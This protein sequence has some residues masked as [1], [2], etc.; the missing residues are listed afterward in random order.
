VNSKQ[1]ILTTILIII[2]ALIPASLMAGVDQVSIYIPSFDGPRELGRN[3]ATVL[4]LQI[5]QT[6]R[7]APWPENPDNLHFGYG[8]IYWDN[9]TLG[10]QSH[11]EAER[12][13]KDLSMLAQMAFWGKAY[14]YGGGVVVQSNLSIPTYNDFREDKLEIW[15]TK[16]NGKTIGLDIPRRRIEMSSIVLEPSII[17]KYSLPSALKM[18]KNQVGDEEVGEVGDSYVAIKFV[19]GFAYVKSKG[20]KGWVRLPELSKRPTEVVDFVAGVIRIFRG[21]WR[22]A[23]TKMQDVIN[24]T[25]TKKPLKI[26]AYLYRGMAL[27][28]LGEPGRK[29]FEHAYKLNPY[30]ETTIQYLIM[31]DLSALNRLTGVNKTKERNTINERIRNTISEH[32]YLFKD[33]NPWLLK[34]KENI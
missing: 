13:I 8:L 20:I 16:L 18:Y 12:A 22:G 1:K 34:V 23:A 30:S 21:D 7:R 17:E 6:L 33:D 19:P 2:L 11:I 28:R 27:E 29:M 10:E 32:G 31:S 4:N 5:W 3:V 25:N 9:E 26:D 15:K 24:N 14:R